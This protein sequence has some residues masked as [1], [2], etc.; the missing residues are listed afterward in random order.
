MSVQLI[1]FE[2][3]V[4]PLFRDR[5]RGAM[6]FAFDLWS[7]ADVSEHA[8]DIIRVLETGYMPCDSRWEADRLAIFRRWANEGKAP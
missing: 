6:L 4:K 1:S 8:G 7:H 2:R 5:D 3:D